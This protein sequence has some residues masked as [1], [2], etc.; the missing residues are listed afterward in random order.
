MLGVVFTGGESPP[1]E[2][3]RR[4]LKGEK[5]F[6]VAA[7]SGLI[8]AEEAGYSPK[9]IIGD[10]DSLDDE[11]R[12]RS[13]P[14]ESIIRY[15]HDKDYTDTE[16]AVQAVIE[17][18]CSMIWIIGGGGGRIDHLFGIRSL[19]ER[20]IFPCRWITDAADIRCIDAASAFGRLSC[21]LGKGEPVSVFPLGIGPWKAK[22]RGLKWPLDNVE[23]NRGFSGLSNEAADG[24]FSIT[25]EKGR[26]LVLLSLGG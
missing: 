4:E 18:G 22:S 23:W 19:F 25:A 2:V 15:D 17:K 24:G 3:I 9:C 26:F 16:L 5:A 12:L 10:M 7:D 11:D 14:P 8:I 6:I 20:D 21:R 1:P 13:Y